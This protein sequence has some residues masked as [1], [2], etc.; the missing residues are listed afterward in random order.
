MLKTHK[1]TAKR[2]KISKGGVVSHKKAWRNHL[3]VNKGRSTKQ[4]KGWRNLPEMEAIRIQT[5]LPYGV[6]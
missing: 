2:F 4:S 5:L 3:L 6:K 1:G